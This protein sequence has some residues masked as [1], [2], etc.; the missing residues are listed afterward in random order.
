VVFDPDVELD[1]DSVDAVERPVLETLLD[2][3]VLVGPDEAALVVLE[4]VSVVWVASVEVVV[5]MVV[6]LGLPVV[7][8]RDDVDEMDDVEIDDVE[9]RPGLAVR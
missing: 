5:E 3:D 9:P 7:V 8:A 6:V 4:D 2:E 1:R